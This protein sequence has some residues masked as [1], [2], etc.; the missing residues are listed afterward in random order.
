VPARPLT[1]RVRPARSYHMV[2]LALFVF[3]MLFG[4]YAITRANRH[5]ARADDSA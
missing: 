1:R 4:M 3:A 2:W 5:V